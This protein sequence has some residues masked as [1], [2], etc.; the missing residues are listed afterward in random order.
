[1]H[2][3]YCAFLQT[4]GLFIAAAALGISYLRAIQNLLAQKK[5]SMDYIELDITLNPPQ[6]FTDI[7]MAAL[8]ELGFESFVENKNGLQAYIQADLYTEN[9]EQES[10][11]WQLPEVE[12]VVNRK[13]IARVNWNETWEKNFEPITVDD[14]VYIHAPFHP[15]LPQFKYNLLIEPKMSFGTGHH[16]T[17]HMMVQHL[18]HID[19]KGKDVLD[20]GCGTGLLAILAAKRGAKA[21]TAIDIDDWAVENTIENAQ[22][23]DAAHIKTLKGG[24]EILGNQT[25]DLILANINKH[26]LLA[27]MAVYNKVLRPGGSIIFSGFYTYDID[28]IA[29]EAA[30]FG[31][32]QQENIS[33]NNWMSANFVK[34]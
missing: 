12:I 24:A 29:L 1:M 21:I 27:D 10:W 5:I 18:L 15:A 9:M 8:G 23:N 34:P 2:F 30:K 3:A 19:A 6:P 13:F 4:K 31:W 17:T 26:V 16:Q 11:A 33:R 25:F 22:R 32:H 14:C 20:M 7:F 28:D